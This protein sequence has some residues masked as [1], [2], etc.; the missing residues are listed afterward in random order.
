MYHVL[1]RY[2]KSRAYHLTLFG[3]LALLR[4]LPALIFCYATSMIGCARG[5]AGVAQNGS[6]QNQ[7]KVKSRGR[8]GAKV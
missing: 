7:L 3:A 1:W 8:E 4:F 6:H 5:C 2:Q